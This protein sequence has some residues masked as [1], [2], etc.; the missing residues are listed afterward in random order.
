MKFKDNVFKMYSCSVHTVVVF[1]HNV[2]SVGIEWG[3]DTRTYKM[4]SKTIKPISVTHKYKEPAG[5]YH[6][7]AMYGHYH[8]YC[9]AYDTFTVRV[10][11]PK[12]TVQ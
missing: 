3:D 10:P 12:L 1:F 4:A 8:S 11:G 9:G 6:I 7:M 5:C 2:C